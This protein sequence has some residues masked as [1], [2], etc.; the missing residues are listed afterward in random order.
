ADDHD[1]VGHRARPRIGRHRRHLYSCHRR[2]H[3]GGGGRRRGSGVV[4]V[5]IAL[6]L[7]GSEL[8]RSFPAQW[9]LALGALFVAVVVFI[10]D[11]I[12]A[13][14]AKWLRRRI[15]GGER[16]LDAEAAPAL[17]PRGAAALVTMTDVRFS[18]GSL[19]VLRGID[20]AI[21]RGR[22]LCIVGPNGAGK[23]TL[24][25]VLTDGRR[26][27]SGAIAF[28]L[29]AGQDH[30]RRP[31]HVIARQGL[32]RKFQIPALFRSL[33]VAE[34]LLLA[35]HRGRWPSPFRRTVRIAVPAAVLD[36]AEA[37]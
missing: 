26:P 21:E 32:V 13:P 28:D 30:Y 11:G 27:I 34:H 37:T 10:P 25:E 16:A 6:R 22:L 23:S 17:P 18:Y 3:G 8:N 36:V 33:T 15:M 5:S 35:A 29:D 24:I 1:R 4:R 12:A 2:R 9:N 20:L 19:Q 14:W 31:P 7:V